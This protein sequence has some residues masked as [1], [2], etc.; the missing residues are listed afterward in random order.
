MREY[1]AL[2]D[3]KLKESTKLVNSYKWRTGGILVSF[4]SLTTFAARFS[5][6]YWTLG[7]LL[8][9]HWANIYSKSTKKNSVNCLFSRV[10]TVDFQQV[11]AQ[12]IAGI[13]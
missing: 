7:M 9:Y 13:L 3:D 6:I 10:F 12:G 11:A 8:L 1:I 2:H 4:C 5:L